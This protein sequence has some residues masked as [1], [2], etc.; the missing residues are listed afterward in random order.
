VATSDAHYVRKEDFHLH[1][2][3]LAVSTG[4][5][6]DDE[7]R[8][9]FE[10]NVNYIMTEDEMLSFGIPQVAIDNTKVIA[11]KCNVEIELGKMNFP[12]IDIPSG[13]TIRDTTAGMRIRRAL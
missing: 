1:D 11:D 8:L 7:N 9:R 3:L 12:Y 13:Y 5:D 6:F 4:K 10:E 2:I